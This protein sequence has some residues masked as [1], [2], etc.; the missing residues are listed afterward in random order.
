MS[1]VR[2]EPRKYSKGHE[3]LYVYPTDINGKPYIEFC[4]DISP[5]DRFLCIPSEDFCEV[6]FALLEQSD[7]KITPEMILNV[8]RR[9]CLED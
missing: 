4:G 1:I 7:V 6:M 9:M 5:K 2:F 8:R 3:C